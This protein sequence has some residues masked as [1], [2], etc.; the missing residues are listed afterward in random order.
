MPN[1]KNILPN[2]LP[3]G[4]FQQL[5]KLIEQSRQQ[6]AL[7]AN[8]AVTLLFWQIGKRINEHILQNKRAAYGKE[9]VVTLA[10]QLTEKYGNNFEHKNLRRMM[11]FAD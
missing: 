7:T 8:S 10:R 3:K 4:L 5:S 1:N 2:S 6:V 9:I 11:Q